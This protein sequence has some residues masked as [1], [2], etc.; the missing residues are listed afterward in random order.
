MYVHTFIQVGLAV[1]VKPE[2]LQCLTALNDLPM[3]I[4]HIGWGKPLAYL[5]MVAKM[6]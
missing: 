5:T 1:I 3:C 6:I 4:P 2:I